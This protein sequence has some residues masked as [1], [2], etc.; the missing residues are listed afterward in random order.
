MTYLVN[1]TQLEAVIVLKHILLS[2]T[3]MVVTPYIKLFK[4]R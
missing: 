1:W 3:D 2:V 4:S